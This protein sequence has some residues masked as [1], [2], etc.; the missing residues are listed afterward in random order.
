MEN[1]NVKERN[2]GPPRVR[3]FYCHELVHVIS[4]CTKRKENRSNKAHTTSSDVMKADVDNRP[5]NVDAG[6]DPLYAPYC[7]IGTI[8]R[9]DG[10]TKSITLLRDIGAL[11]SLFIAVS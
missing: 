9:P 1:K 2:L 6:I 10:T 3:C 8:T 4:Q 5:T 7:C 11:Q